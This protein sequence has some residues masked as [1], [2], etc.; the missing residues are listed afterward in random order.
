MQ[1]LISSNPQQAADLLLREEVVALPTETVYGLAG[2]IYSEKAV[3]KIYAAKGRPSSNPL[4]VHVP[5]GFDYWE[6]AETV[7]D[8]AFEL[9]RR[10]SPGPLTLLLPR[11]NKVPDQVTAGSPRVAIR[12]PDHPLF[13][14]VLQLTQL[15]LAAPSANRYNQISP[16]TAAHV[17]SELGGR[18]PF[19]LDGGK[20]SKGLESTILGWEEGRP[21]VYRHGAVTLE[22]LRPLLPEVRDKAAEEMV[23]LALP[24]NFKKHYSPE[25]PFRLVEKLERYS[26]ENLSDS[27]VL[28]CFNKPV[29]S[30]P[31]ERQRVL[32]PGGNLEEAAARLYQYLR[33]LD[34]LGASLIIGENVPD[35]GIGKAINDRLR[36]A[37]TG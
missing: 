30:I 34:T 28:L 37:A 22:M 26:L 9:I 10:F 6:L 5:I 12:M 19:I 11:N 35:T 18:I 20:C 33:E 2:N 13:Q 31:A 8:E 3:Q 36:K 27:T 21:V 4:I 7:P 29:P 25:T 23:S 17:L 32:S 1:T 16:V 14:Q 24:G 15:P